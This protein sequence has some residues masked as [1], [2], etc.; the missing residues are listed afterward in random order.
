MPKVIQNLREKLLEEAKR[1]IEENG[2]SATTIRSVA[3]ACG[4][5]VGTV[6]NYF[7][8][9]DALLASYLLQDWQK[10]ITAIRALS[11]VSPSPAP[12][13]RCVYDQLRDFSS[14]NA[15]LF[16]DSAAH[17]AFSGSFSRYH[18]LLRAQL[19]GPIR[20]YCD[21]DF[22]AEFVSEAL[23]TWTTQGKAFEDIYN[24]VKKVLTIQGE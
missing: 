2:Y 13:L 4:I 9:K 1:Q 17:S 23:L 3:Q 7:P 5:G 11:D 12:V 20:K 21:S 6:Y 24:M 22:A 14:L 18:G 16:N 19:A 8:S 15:P 10:C